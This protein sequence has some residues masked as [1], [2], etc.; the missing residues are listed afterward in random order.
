MPRDWSTDFQTIFE[1]YKL[2]HTLDLYLA[3]DSALH[4]SRGSVV[5]EI[6]EEEV[7]YLKYIR[8]VDDLSSSLEQTVDRITIKCQNVNSI[9]GFNIASNLRLLD[10]ATADYGKVYQ[11]LRNPALIEDIPQMFRGVLANAE[12]DEQFFNVELII[13]YESLGLIIASRGLAPKCPWWFKNGLECQSASVSD[14]CAKTRKACKKN[15]Y[16]FGFGGWEDFE[17]PTNSAPG[18]GTGGGGIGSCF[19]GDTLIW[20][21]QGSIPIGE[22]PARLKRGEK[23]CFSF[24]PKTGEVE[25]DEIVK[26][27]RHEVTGYFTFDFEHSSL[28]VT[29]EHRLFTALDTFVVADKFKRSDT[30]RAFI[31]T[32]FDSPLKRIKWHSDK[33]TVVW[34]LHIR[35]NQTYFANECGVHNNKDGGE[36]ILV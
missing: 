32:W 26:V 28:N 10:Y 25:E 23:S 22:I 8:S 31:E 17:E 35:K 20:T 34:N 11:S 21:P 9:L 12:A 4:L 3:D 2:R 6:D 30:V 15:L 14:S 24:N 36:I 33:Q 1:A 13:D 5:R 27:F 19:T 29:P 16:E 7:E 18:S